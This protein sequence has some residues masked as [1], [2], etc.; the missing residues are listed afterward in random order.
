[1]G[2]V[3]TFNTFIIVSTSFTFDVTVFTSVVSISVLTSRA[4][5]SWWVNSSGG[6]EFTIVNF[7]GTRST[8]WSTFFTSSVFTSVFSTIDLNGSKTTSGSGNIIGVGVDTTF[9]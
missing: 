3:S 1:V 7:S 2:F 5:T 9:I 6:T 8:L 4:R